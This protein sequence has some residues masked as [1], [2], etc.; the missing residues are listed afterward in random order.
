[1][2]APFAST[3]WSLIAELHGEPEPARRALAELCDIYWPAVY[4]W[5]RRDGNSQADAED[6]TQGFFA[7]LLE[8]DGIQ[9]ANAERGRFRSFLMACLKHFTANERARTG[10]VKR[11]GR[12]RV[13]GGMTTE[14][15]EE[16][17]RADQVDGW[18]PERAFER[19]YAVSLL[20]RALA[21]LRETY[22]DKGQ[23][24]V[25]DRLAPFLQGGAD[26]GFRDV[27]ESAGVSEGAARVALHRM[28]KRYGDQIRAEIADTLADS[29]GEGI[30]E[31]LSQLLQA[32]SR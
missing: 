15:I 1:M 4:A 28:K 16:A 27:A 26:E 21:S 13:V 6:L 29:N 12:G 7:D 9:Q 2:T 22:A 8:R 17:C 11:G 24:G 32:I 20:S 18:T 10:A 5:L 25:F 31:E 23:S 19:Q 14:Q 3:R 30:E